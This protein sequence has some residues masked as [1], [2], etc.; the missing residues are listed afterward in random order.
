MKNVFI[1]LKLVMEVIREPNAV[2]VLVCLACIFGCMV[3]LEV[4]WLASI[5]LD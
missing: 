3:M 2:R 4:M 1:F 5:F